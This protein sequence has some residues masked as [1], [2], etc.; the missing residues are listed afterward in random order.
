MRKIA[1]FVGNLAFMS[2]VVMILLHMV[3]LRA[4][5][6]IERLVATQCI[7]LRG[8]TPR[9]EMGWCTLK[10]AP[11]FQVLVWSSRT[12]L[13]VIVPFSTSF[14][15]HSSHL[16]GGRLC[17]ATRRFSIKHPCTGAR[18]AMN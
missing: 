2:V 6:V 10:L 1:G 11:A 18:V 12:V 15:Q 5:Y 3:V 9:F 14:G 7:A 4:N 8:I 16:R 13:T 17:S